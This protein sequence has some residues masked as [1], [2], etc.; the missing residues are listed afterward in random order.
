MLHV[1]CHMRV[2]IQSRFEARLFVLH[3]FSLRFTGSKFLINLQLQFHVRKI[4]SC[5]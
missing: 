1:T 5:M 3:I 2:M 4:F